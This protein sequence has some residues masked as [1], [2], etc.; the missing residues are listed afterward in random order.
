VAGIAHDKLQ[1][2][3]QRDSGG[4]GVRPADGLARA[5][6]IRVD[7]TITLGRVAVRS[8]GPKSVSVRVSGPGN[9]NRNRLSLR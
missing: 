9:Q 6:E 4:D 7:L 8:G 1:A 3:P 2:V 5:F